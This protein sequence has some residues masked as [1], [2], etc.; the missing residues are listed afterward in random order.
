MKTS[1]FNLIV[2]LFVSF[3]L[4]Y[5]TFCTIDVNLNQ[6]EYI[7]AR[8]DPFECRRLIAALHYTS[9]ELP[10]SLAA[11]E[12]TIDE[13]IPCIRHLIHWNS[14]PAEGLGQSHEALVHRLRALG[15]DD[16]ADWLG[17]STFKQ[18][19]MDM[20]RIMDQPFDKL[21]EQET[22]A[23]FP[24]TINP[25]EML[26]DDDYW[27]QLNIVLLA[28]MLGLMGTLLILI[29]YIIFYIIKVRSRRTKYRKMKQEGDSEKLFKPFEK[30][31][32]KNNKAKQ[33]PHNIDNLSD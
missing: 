4:P 6:L 19:G 28:I 11:A 13:E 29:G 21:G 25:I 8:L 12:R 26:E 5:V 3:V 20:A 2:Y 32:Q 30:E 27:S 33:M 10:M 18:L 31:K 17:K 7:A 16:L 15:R 9:Y 23:S 1:I 24:L 14:S 22:E